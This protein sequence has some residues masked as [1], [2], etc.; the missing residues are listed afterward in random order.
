[1]K[2]AKIAVINL[3]SAIALCSAC[4][5]AIEVPDDFKTKKKIDN[6]QLLAEVTAHVINPTA[7][8]SFQI[9]TNLTNCNL[10]KTSPSIK[11]SGLITEVDQ[12]GEFKVGDG[13]L[14]LC[15]ESTTCNL[16]GFYSGNGISDDFGVRISALVNIDQGKG[17]FMADGGQLQLTLIGE[18]LSKGL[19]D[20][21]YTI[22]VNG[23][24]SNE[25]DN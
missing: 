18:R 3:L 24:L 6:I 17:Q 2:S 22:D 4:L 9:C 10:V 25:I 15:L 23:Y 1:M 5:D 20:M 12:S 16:I 11:L 14:Y 19:Q 7:G 21:K 13:V 8:E